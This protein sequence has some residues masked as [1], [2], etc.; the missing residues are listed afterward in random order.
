MATQQ[1]DDSDTKRDRVNALIS[2]E[3]GERLRNAVDYLS[4]PPHRLRLNST[5]EAAILA[6]VEKL[7]REHHKGKPFP[8]RPGD[9]QEGRRV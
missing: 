5:V 7:E 4:G 1:K 2:R 8:Q 9:L 6:H 3:L